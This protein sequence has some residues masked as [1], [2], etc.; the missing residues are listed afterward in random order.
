MN[1][2]N[3]Q[4]PDIDPGEPVAEL[5]GLAEPP[6][7]GFLGRIRRGIQLKVLASDVMELAFS[8][9]WRFLQEIA[10]LIFGALGSSRPNDGDSSR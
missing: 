2:E 8:A 9:S 4:G 3:E 6:S 10:D 1:D 5:A 7:S